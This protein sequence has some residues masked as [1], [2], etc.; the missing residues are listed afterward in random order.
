M[1]V[2]LSSAC[3]PI[4]IFLGKYLSIDD[5]SYRFVVDQGIFSAQS[6]VPSFSLHFLAQNINVPTTVLEWP[7]FE[8][9]EAELRSEHYE[10]FG[11]TFKFLD[12]YTIADMIDL[13]RRVSPDTK[14]ILG[15]YG[16]LTL[17]EP[18]YA[19]IKNDVD[20][21]CKGGDGVHFMRNLLGDMEPRPMVCQ[22]PV[23]VVR[24]PWL[25]PAFGQEIAYMLSALGCVWKCEFCC[26]SAYTAGRVVDVMSAREM[27]DSMKWYYT[28][29]PKMGQ[30]YVMD[31][32]ILLRKKKVDAIGELLRNDEKGLSQLAYLSFGTVKAVSRWDPEELLLNGVSHVWTGI[33]SLYSYY[34]KKGDADSQE[35]MRTLSEYGIETQLSWIVGDDCQTPENIQADVDYFIGHYP[36]TAQLSSLSAFPGTA[37]YNRL[38]T[39]GRIKNMVPEEAHL[40]GNNMDSTHFTHD[41]RIGLIMDIYRQMYE[42]LGS[43][44]MRSLQVYLNGYDVCRRSDNPFLNRDKA[45]YFQ[46]KIEKYIPFATVAAEYAPNEHVKQLSIDLQKRHKELLGPASTS[47]RHLTEWIMQRADAETERRV[48]HPYSSLRDIPLKRYSYDGQQSVGVL[49]AQPSQ[50]TIFA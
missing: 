42:T 18:E 49:T 22:M 8:E 47:Q 4:P 17:D 7:T 14:I 28:N 12:M 26:T 15:G 45:A 25:P 23:E 40:L 5:V 30:I 21:V 34:R 46:K 50:Q 13:V 32:E 38:K 31:E 24:L 44:M 43:S 6:D 39:E 41:E 48:H 1:K 16:T 35:L 10:Y 11:I 36:T 20:Y 27:Y 37:L 29:H 2:L 3:K 33:E 19:H 9:L